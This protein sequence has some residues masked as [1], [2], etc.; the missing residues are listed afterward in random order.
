[1]TTLVHALDIEV[2]HRRIGPNRLM[3]IGSCCIEM[4]PRRCELLHRFF[5]TIDW[6][7]PL[8][9]DYATESFWQRHPAALALNTANGVPPAEAAS[10]LVRHLI[11]LHT[12][13]HQRNARLVTVT[14]N[15]YFDV[16]WIDW[17]VS[18]YTSNG[19][20]LQHTYTAGWRRPGSC[21]DLGERMRGLRDVGIEL[22]LANFVSSAPHDHHPLN[23]AIHIAERYIWYVHHCRWIARGRAA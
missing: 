21:V 5:I 2:S 19:L 18:K 20:P 12:V 8:E 22:P 17:F 10:A 11:E 3:S 9:Y 15:A 1:M 4:G 6:G 13:A 7:T 23:D 16:G 14:D